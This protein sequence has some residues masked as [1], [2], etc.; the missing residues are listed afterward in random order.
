MMSGKALS[1]F[2]LYTGQR[3][4]DLATLSWDNIDL[5]RNE[6]RL[7]TR[8][9]HKRLAIPIAAPLRTH[10]DSL[11]NTDKPGSWLHPKAAATIARQKRSGTLSNQFADLL[12]QAGLREK[13]AHKSTGKGRDGQRQSGGLSFH[14]LRHTA[15]SLLK[16]PGF[17]KPLSWN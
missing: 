2:G 9:T 17:P 4:A 14:A 7:V 3:L 16:M 5:A 6:I 10:I 15:V 12:A 8:K 13:T 1:C 11:P